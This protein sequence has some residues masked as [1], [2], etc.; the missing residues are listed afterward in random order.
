MEH[1]EKQ[2]TVFTQQ[3]IEK[4]LQS[5]LAAA[6]PD[7]WSKLDLSAV[8]E[9]PAKSGEKN[10]RKISAFHRR[11]G[12]LCAAAC[13]C[14]TV[15]GGGYYHYE[16]VQ[17]VS[18][19]G[20]DVNPSLK[21]LLNRKD[22]VTEAQGLNEDGQALLADTNLKGN[23]VEDAVDQVMSSLV[24]QGYL[25]A[26]G[27]KNAVLV[28]VSGRNQ[29]KAE[30][31]KTEV[32]ANVE[33]TLTEKQ[34]NAVVYDQTIQVTDE[35]KELAENYQVSPGKAEFVG[36]L[37]NENDTLNSDI[38]SSYER[39]M[40]QTMEELTQEIQENEYYVSSKVTIIKAEPVSKQEERE[41]AGRDRD[42][43]RDRQEN[44]ADKEVPADKEAAVSVETD[45][46]NGAEVSESA[47]ESAPAEETT[48]QDTEQIDLAAAPQESPRENLDEAVMEPADVPQETE[49]REEEV[50]TS[51][52]PEE[53]ADLQEPAESAEQK[54]PEETGLPEAKEEK[55]QAETESESQEEV[56]VPAD[57][58]ATPA[59]AAS[60][61]D[62]ENSREDE[63]GAEESIPEDEKDPE[64]PGEKTA[65]SEAEPEKDTDREQEPEESVSD[66][67]KEEIS[68]SESDADPGSDSTNDE[69][70]LDMTNN[71]EVLDVIR[72][73]ETV[74]EKEPE[75][76][77][78]SDDESVPTDSVTVDAKEETSQNSVE[79]IPSLE[80]EPDLFG[81]GDAIKYSQTGIQITQ[82]GT[83]I[84]FE[85]KEETEEKKTVYAS[86][87]LSGRERQ[88]IRKG[89]G[90]Y[91]DAWS[92]G[93]PEEMLQPEIQEYLG[94][95][96]VLQQDMLISGEI[97]IP[98][99]YRQNSGAVSII[100]MK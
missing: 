2:N 62:S 95:R 4:H 94:V 64:L 34:V 84:I 54:E 30:A 88:L 51:W 9:R 71:E 92:E 89:P 7:V 23:T 75:E 15:M 91:P 70:A 32:S 3:D 48:G 56:C 81:P 86:D 41:L 69:E 13:V 37:V 31:V 39:M 66:P 29:K 79:I 47:G 98:A 33:K 22:R 82:N 38:Q 19:V 78:E 83:Q 20:I 77:V 57:G 25:N 100:K 27:A 50:F 35:L 76:G 68:D 93:V 74:P 14:L 58:T 46:E 87:Y 10:G 80:K 36:L 61:A 55:D 60:K 72:D 65:V 59:D 99:V 26:D 5:A 24:D 73:A 53:E 11:F 43:K 42:E 67:S 17:V 1:R 21:L 18:E 6:T 28:S 16:Y 49:P 96:G 52:E 85:P 90:M 40:G 63:S 44:S 12:G 8:Q 45:H 97:L